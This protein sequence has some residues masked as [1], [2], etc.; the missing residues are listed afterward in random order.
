MILPKG[1]GLTKEN[2]GEYYHKAR[3]SKA[4]Q[5][6]TTLSKTFISLTQK[7]KEEILA[8]HKKNVQAA[9]ER[10]ESGHGGVFIVSEGGR[11]EAAGA[12]S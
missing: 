2:F 10:Q 4:A 5:T 6:L 12:G 3:E 8:R 7:K 9:F 11:G 1:A